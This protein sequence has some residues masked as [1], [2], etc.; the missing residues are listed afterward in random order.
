MKDFATNSESRRKD[1]KEFAGLPASQP[2]AAYVA[3]DEHV[4]RLTE[5][6]ERLPR[7]NVQ[8]ESSVFNRRACSSELC[9]TNRLCACFASF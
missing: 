3:F 5:V 8:F 1:E 4:E 7:S 6:A 2:I 9:W